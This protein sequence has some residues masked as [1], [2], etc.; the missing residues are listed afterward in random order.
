M[1]KDK[2]KEISESIKGCYGDKYCE[3]D[4]INFTELAKRERTKKGLIQLVENLFDL[5]H[6]DAKDMV[7][8]MQTRGNND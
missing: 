3:E 1:S 5:D 7:G 6:A 2:I 4:H 8:Q